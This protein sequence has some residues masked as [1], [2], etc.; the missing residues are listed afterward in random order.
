MEIARLNIRQTLPRIGIRSQLAKLESHA[1]QP[2]ISGEY[3]APRSNMGVTQPQISMDSYSSRHSY[4][5]TNHEDFAREKGQEGVQK[6]RE[7]MARN[8]SQGMDVVNNGAKKGHRVFIEQAK[9]QISEQINKQRYMEIAPIPD[10]SVNITPG[11]VEGTPDPGHQNTRIDT[12]A[13]AQVEYT[14]GYV[15]TY[16]AQKGDIQRWVTWGKYDIYA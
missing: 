13:F 1:T 14:P 6:M 7:E 5:Y 3:Q 4:G 9:R 15:E 2:R 10:P 16:L 8:N 11:R 12:D